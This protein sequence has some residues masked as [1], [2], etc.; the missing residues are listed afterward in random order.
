MPPPFEGFSARDKLMLTKITGIVLRLVFGWWT[1]FVATTIIWPFWVSWCLITVGG[2][3]TPPTRNLV[4]I[5]SISWRWTIIY[6]Y[7][8]FRTTS[9]RWL[10][11]ATSSACLACGGW[12][13]GPRCPSTLSS[14]WWSQPSVS[15]DLSRHRS[16]PWYNY[17]ETHISLL[18]LIQYILINLTTQSISSGFSKTAII[19]KTSSSSWQWFEI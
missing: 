15:K 17:W 8:Y 10:H 18:I 7:T 9:Y 14:F 4:K 3:W 11:S 6:P 2:F 16:W 1:E 12:L 19:K 13:N 5:S